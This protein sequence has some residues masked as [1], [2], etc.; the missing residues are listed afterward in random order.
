MSVRSV[1]SGKV[2][3]SPSKRAELEGADLLYEAEPAP[4]WDF[5]GWRLDGS[6]AGDDDTVALDVGEDDMA[7][8]AVFERRRHTLDLR[9]TGGTGTLTA[10]EPGPYSDGDTVSVTAV[11]A[12]GFVFT[13]WLLDGAPYGGDE[14]RAKGETAVS[15]EERGHTLTAV[16]RPASDTTRSTR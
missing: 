5:A 2:V 10:S 4:G 3:K 13:D 16:F 6:A 8:T 9:T 1:G 14:E 11:P 7:L 15:F 12:P